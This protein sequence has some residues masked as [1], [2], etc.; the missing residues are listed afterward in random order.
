MRNPT[1]DTQDLVL[2]SGKSSKSTDLPQLSSHPH[3]IKR[4]K[5]NTAPCPYDI[6]QILSQ[7]RWLRKHQFA[8]PVRPVDTGSGHHLRLPT[9]SLDDSA[10]HVWESNVAERRSGLKNPFCPQPLPLHT[11]GKAALAT[12][13]TLR[14]D[15]GKPK[16]TPKPLNTPLN[17]KPL[18]S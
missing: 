4:L 10:S 18:S 7:Q 17:P 11:S 5:T 3:G 6:S 2:L 15:T 9:V 16:T 1:L 14:A 12:N 13:E 8:G